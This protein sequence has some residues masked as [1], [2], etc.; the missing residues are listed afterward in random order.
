[1]N[2]V[3]NKTYIKVI[4]VVIVGAIL[5][6]T[7]GCVDVDYM[8]EINEGEMVRT[9]ILARIDKETVRDQGEIEEYVQT[10]LY[11]N[12]ERAESYNIYEEDNHYLFEVF[13]TEGFRQFPFGRQ[14]GIVTTSHSDRTGHF[15][16]VGLDTTGYYKR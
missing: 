3:G 1:M 7:G 4:F 9:S 13:I 6:L 5:M 15:Y 10:N 11:Q 2:T 12:L 8:M 16:N 14:L